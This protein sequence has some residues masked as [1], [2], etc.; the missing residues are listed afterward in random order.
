MESCIGDIKAWMI[1]DKLKI[2]NGKTK[3]ML[4]GT[5]QQSVKI[6]VGGLCNGNTIISPAS[7]TKILG[8]MV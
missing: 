3:L 8:S 2:N 6:N 7:A 4:L 5:K 1:T